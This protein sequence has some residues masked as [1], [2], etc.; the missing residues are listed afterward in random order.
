MWHQK[1]GRKLGTDASHRKALLVGLTKELIKHERIK[2]TEA[3][4]KEMRT[5]SDK[6]ITLAKKGNLHSR[7][8]ALA[9]INDRS[10]V[11][12][13][14]TEIAPRFEERNG[15]YTRILKLGTRQGDAARMVIIE[16]V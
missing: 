4:A 9:I 2:T 10:L 13:L 11:D 5:L 12:K 14:F 8:Q 3:R 16:L 6:V 7:R 15:G 1:K